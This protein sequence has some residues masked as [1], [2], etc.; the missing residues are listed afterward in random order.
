MLSTYLVSSRYTCVILGE[1]GG[2]VSLESEDAMQVD[3][4]QNADGKLKQICISLRH[5]LNYEEDD[6]RSETLQ[7][8]P[9][10]MLDKLP[11]TDLFVYRTDLT[12]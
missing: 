8:D 11:R 12:G 10:S 5:V 9:G 7:E 4:E 1:P 6:R 2:D 3:K